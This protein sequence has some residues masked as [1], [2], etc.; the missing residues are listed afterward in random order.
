LLGA[1]LGA[2]ATGVW[3]G[4]LGMLVGLA[5]DEWEHY[6][7]LRHTQ[8]TPALTPVVKSHDAPTVVAL[9]MLA[10][11]YAFPAL[12]KPTKA[13]AILKN[14]YAL[15]ASTLR[16]I[17]RIVAAEAAATSEVDYAM[18]QLRIEGTGKPEK[19]HDMLSCLLDLAV[20]STTPGHHTLDRATMATLEQIAVKLNYHV[21]DFAALATIKGYLPDALYDPYQILGLP[22]GAS[23]DAAA[24]AYKRLVQEFHPDRWQGRNTFALQRAQEKTVLINDAYHKI[25]KAVGA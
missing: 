17:G 13:I 10:K 5:Y 6:L 23:L 16:Y 9:V 19:L 11:A 1:V 21:D 12:A 4:L 24:K 20:D 7:S 25:K 22:T 2:V 14:F 3:G 15:N 18:T 8:P